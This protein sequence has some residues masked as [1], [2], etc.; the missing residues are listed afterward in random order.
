MLNY[1]NKS[2]QNKSATAKKLIKILLLFL[3]ICIIVF[4]TINNYNTSTAFTGTAEAAVYSY[5]AEISGKIVDMPFN[6]GESVKK[7]E[8][9]LTIDSRDQN[10]ALQQLEIN[11]KKAK[12]AL[13]DSSLKLGSKTSNEYILA[14]A[15]YNSALATSTQAGKDY[16]DTLVLYEAGAVPE[17]EL[18]KVK[19]QKE[20]AEYATNAAKAKLDLVSSSAGSD[21][22]AL[23]ISE[24]EL[25]IDQAKSNL[26]KYTIAA[27]QDGVIISKSYAVG[28]T[29]SAG[30]TLTEIGSSN[31]KYLTFY[32]PEEMRNKVDYGEEINFIYN[33][34]NY[35]GQVSYIDLKKQYTPIDL[36]TT[37]N[38]NKKSFKVKISI[39]KECPINP[40]EEATVNI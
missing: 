6:L 3:I 2:M 20:S 9:L 19:L 16:E 8:T 25:Q 11:L 1:G 27:G 29:I 26:D 40:G 13:S 14:S 38:K 39:D 21:T 15:N 35:L 30:Q 34:K 12:L 24:M 23:N 18:E 32:L 31:E 10:Y 7:G 17:K 22:L 5:S 4:L 33:G 36:Q 37:A 28:D